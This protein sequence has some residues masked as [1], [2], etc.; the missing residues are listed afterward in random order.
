MKEASEE[1]RSS[2]S[3]NLPLGDARKVANTILTQSGELNA[4]ELAGKIEDLVQAN[5]ELAKKIPVSQ[6]RT[7]T[8][9]PELSF[10]DKL[11]LLFGATLKIDVTVRFN[12]KN[13]SEILCIEK[14]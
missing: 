4:T 14:I 13:I 3:L 7:D 2:F 8:I 12:G 1:A 6:S 10:V 5:V 9:I 11:R